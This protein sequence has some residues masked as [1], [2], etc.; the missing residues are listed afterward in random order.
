MTR[1]LHGAC[2][3][4][5]IRVMMECST[6][7]EK[8]QL[9]ACQCGFCRRHGGLLFSDPE[10]Q[11]HI[12]ATGGSVHRYRFGQAQSDYLFC[13]GCGAYIGAVAETDV[14]TLGIVNVRGVDMHEFEGREGERMNFEGETIEQ[15]NARRKAKW[16]PAVLVELR[17]TA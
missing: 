13:N 15:R 11:L 8:L 4:G 1:R 7:P 10:G 14:G 9:R 17:A 3:C 6:A 16:T 5:S 12:E 2:H